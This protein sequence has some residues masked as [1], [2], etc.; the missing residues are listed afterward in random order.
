LRNPALLGDTTTLDILVTDE[1]GYIYLYYYAPP[2]IRKRL[3][4]GAPRNDAFD[5]QVLDNYRR[6]AHWANI[7]LR[8]VTYDEFFL[9]HSDFLVYSPNNSAYRSGCRNCTQ[10]FL[11]AGYT[12]RSV[13]EDPDNL[14]EHFSK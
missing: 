8:L 1:P 6:L 11:N 3:V 4:F 7:D 10:E 14:L 2:Q 13:K 12:L 5:S 9:T